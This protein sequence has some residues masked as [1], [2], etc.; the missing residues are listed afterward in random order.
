MFARENHIY[1]LVLEAFP[2]FRF[3]LVSKGNGGGTPLAN[4]SV[5]HI[6]EEPQLDI[7]DC[8]ISNQSSSSFSIRCLVVGPTNPNTSFIFQVQFPIPGLW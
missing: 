2:G 6:A 7:K 5:T 1:L 3:S 4:T 8:K